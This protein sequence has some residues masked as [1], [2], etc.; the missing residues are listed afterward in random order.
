MKQELKLNLGQQIA[1]NFAISA[2]IKLYRSKKFWIG[3]RLM[4][5]RGASLNPRATL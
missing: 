1:Q 3:P 2:Q 4:K 5:L